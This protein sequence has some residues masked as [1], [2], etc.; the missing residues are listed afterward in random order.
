MYSYKLEMERLRIYQ[1]E[2][3]EALARRKFNQIISG[4]I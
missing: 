4:K 2:M 1:N 3:N